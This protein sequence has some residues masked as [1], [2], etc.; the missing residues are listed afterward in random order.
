MKA[1]IQRIS[2]LIRVLLGAA[3][4]AGLALVPRPPAASRAA[5]AP[6]ALLEETP[7]PGRLGMSRALS[8]SNTMPRVREVV[9]AR[10]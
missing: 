3:V 8:L 2:A 1:I 7:T 5:V 9:T 4:L 6:R 10:V